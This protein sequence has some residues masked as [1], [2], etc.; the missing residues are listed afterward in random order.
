VGGILIALL[1]P[2]MFFEGSL[3]EKFDTRFMEKLVQGNEKGKTKKKK[4]VKVIGIPR[5]RVRASNM[6]PPPPNL[7]T[8]TQELP[9]FRI[10]QSILFKK[11]NILILSQ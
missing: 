10:H 7:E 9:P 1:T 5:G 6:E 2:F 3:R 4:D 8:H 11:L